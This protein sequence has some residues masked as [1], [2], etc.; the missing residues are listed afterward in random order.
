MPVET[1][2]ERR[3][4]LP[5]R[6]QEFGALERLVELVRVFPVDAIQRDAR[7]MRCAGLVEHHDLPAVVQGI[8]RH[9]LGLLFLAA[10]AHGGGQRE[11]DG[12]AS[13]RGWRNH[14]AK[15]TV[16]VRSNAS[17]RNPLHPDAVNNRT[18]TNQE[19]RP[20]E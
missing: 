5:R 18:R 20:C 6:L 1:A 9:W 7:E 4:Q 15:V 17:S 10:G 19:T 14:V 8:H 2:E 13:E 11:D 16:A 3:V 12:V